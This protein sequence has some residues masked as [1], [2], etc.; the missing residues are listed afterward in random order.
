VFGRSL[1]FPIK[2]V[3][4]IK[5]PDKENY[6]TIFVVGH[7]FSAYQK[8][9]KDTKITHTKKDALKIHTKILKEAIKNAY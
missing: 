1:Y 7:F 6:H 9:R 2:T 4:T 8:E 3:T 5:E